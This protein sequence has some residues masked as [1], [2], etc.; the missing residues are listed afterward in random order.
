MAK[1]G[2]MLEVNNIT[3]KID[4]KTILEGVSA[5]FKPGQL[6]MIIGPNGSGKS[7]LL[8]IICNEITNY[9]GDV[10]YNGAILSKKEKIAIAQKR[11]VLS[12]QSE[13]SFPLPVE[14]VV[15]M[16][17]YPHFSLHP[18]AKD[19]EICLQALK[20]MSIA[21]FRYRNYLTLSGGEKQRVHFARALA[22]I[23]EQPQTPKGA[24]SECR[25]LFLDE[26]IAS[27]DLNYQHEFLRITKEITEQNT[28]VVAVIHDIN[29]ALQYADQVVLIN[30]GYAIANG[31]PSEVITA[32]NL[33]AVYGLKCRVLQNS[34][35]NFRYFIV[36]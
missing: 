12:Q 10:L 15:M 29:L 30:M 27:L 25:Y 34:G 6:N 4:E 13:L 36:D 24:L 35:S 23:W 1:E 22:Q 28:V 7:T 5:C 33:F 11:A 21:D 26:P 20:R 31:K 32:E 3:Y 19:K 9:T 16:G 17:R 14:E 18:S 8:K 2:F